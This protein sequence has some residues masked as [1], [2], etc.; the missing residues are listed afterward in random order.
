MLTSNDIITNSRSGNVDNSGHISQ[1]HEKTKPHNSAANIELVKSK[2][3]DKTLRKET[4][5]SPPDP[6]LKNILPLLN[7]LSERLSSESAVIKMYEIFSIYG[8]SDEIEDA[9]ES[10]IQFFEQALRMRKE[11]IEHASILTKEIAELAP[12]DTPFQS[13]L[14]PS[15][16]VPEDLLQGI[17]HHNVSYLRALKSIYT[18]EL[19]SE[20]EDG[21]LQTQCN[22]AGL[23]TLSAKIGK[24]ASEKR[25]HLQIL[26]KWIES[27]TFGGER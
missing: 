8:H 19:I 4:R 9:S 11:C 22:N 7:R 2:N 20:F 13:F 3:Y 14:F 25:S 10:D 26:R 12:A 16:V 21:L 24:I 18:A 5:K 6:T 1:K 17:E 23:T 15:P 27:K